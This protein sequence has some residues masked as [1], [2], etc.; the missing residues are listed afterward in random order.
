MALWYLCCRDYSAG[1]DAGFLE[2]KAWSI[3]G[4]VQ[5]YGSRGTLG[6]G[7]FQRRHDS[8]SEGELC[9]ITLFPKARKV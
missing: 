7:V 5:R 2:R 1:A 8:S 4:H 3:H 6:P 9:F